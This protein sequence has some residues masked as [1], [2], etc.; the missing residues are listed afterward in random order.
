ME[1]PLSLSRVYG[2]HEP[3]V[4]RQMLPLSSSG[5]EGQ[6][7]EAHPRPIPSVLIRFMEGPHGRR[8]RHWDQKPAKFKRKPEDDQLSLTPALPKGRGEGKEMRMLP[9]PCAK[10]HDRPALPNTQ[11]DSQRGPFAPTQYLRS[12]RSVRSVPFTRNG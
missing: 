6:G 3:T 10:S 8:A 9:Q 12:V 11:T 2:G 1:N 5:G 7:E 4:A